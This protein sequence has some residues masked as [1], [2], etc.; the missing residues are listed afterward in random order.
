[1]VFRHGFLGVIRNFG[2]YEMMPLSVPFPMSAFKEGLY[3]QLVT[4]QVREFLDLETTHGLKSSVEAL[5][6]TDYPD[7]LARHLV[8][9]IKTALRG[10]PRK[11]GKSGRASW[12]THC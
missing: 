7:Y 9:Q 1:M 4:R 11:T 6:E 3:D 2:G 10:L 5:E 8:R 12:R